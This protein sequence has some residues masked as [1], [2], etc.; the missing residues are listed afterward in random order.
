VIEVHIDQARFIVR[1]QRQFDNVSPAAREL[2]SIKTI[3]G[4]VGNVSGLTKKLK[5]Q[6]ALQ[7]VAESTPVESPAF[8]IHHS[9]FRKLQI[10]PG[11]IDLICTDVVWSQDC[12]KDWADL[13]TLAAK[14][15][16]SNGMFVSLVGQMHLDKFIQAICPNLK[17]VTTFASVFANGGRNINRV[18]NVAEGWRSAAIFAPIDQQTDLNRVSDV[19]DS[20]GPEKEYHEWQ[21]T[22]GVVR[23]LVRRLAPKEGPALICDPCLGSGTTAVAVAQLR[24]TLSF[25]GCDIDAEAVKIAKHRL[26]AEG[27]AKRTAG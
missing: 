3:G 4:F 13:G 26:A 25:V 7:R 8:K 6:E 23:E 22:L 27:F 18:L 5:R 16:K 9:D 15:L 20:S 1:N 10:E 14:W 24:D 21:Q 2:D 17:Y 19:I 12:V 11:T